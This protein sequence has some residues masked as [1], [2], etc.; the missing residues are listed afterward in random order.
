MQYLPI[1]E[2]GAPVQPTATQ[3][4]AAYHRREYLRAHASQFEARF[5]SQLITAQEW[6]AHHLRLAR[7]LEGAA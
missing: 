4:L 7:K 6:M 3:Q 2:T 5:Q 1:T